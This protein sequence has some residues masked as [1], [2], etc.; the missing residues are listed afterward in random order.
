MYKISLRSGEEMAADNN[1]LYTMQE[2][3]NYYLKSSSYVNSMMYPNISQ[4]TVTIN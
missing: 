3:R 4:P 2:T 1:K